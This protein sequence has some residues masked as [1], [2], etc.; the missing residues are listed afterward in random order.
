[1]MI[2]LHLLDF[3]QLDWWPNATGSWQMIMM[4][5]MAMMMG[6]VMVMVMMRDGDDDGDDDGDYEKFEMF[7]V[8]TLQ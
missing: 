2:A 4:M 7:I 5:M 8:D 3:L 1:M 6:M